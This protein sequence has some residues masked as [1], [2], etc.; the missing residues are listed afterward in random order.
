[1]QNCTCY[2]RWTKVVAATKNWPT[3]VSIY[4]NLRRLFIQH[5]WFPLTT[6]ISKCKGKL[7]NAIT[8]PQLSLGQMI[9]NRVSAAHPKSTGP[10]ANLQEIS[11]IRFLPTLKDQTLLF[12]PLESWLTSLMLS[13]LWR[14]F[15]SFTSPISTL[16]RCLRNKRRWVFTYSY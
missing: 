11:K 1:M 4:L 12:L 3:S 15:A 7:C 16:M 2:M 13:L 6:W 14:M 9:E 5:F 8:K 10:K